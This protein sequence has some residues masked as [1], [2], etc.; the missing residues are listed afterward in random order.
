MIINSFRFLNGSAPE[1]P[2][3]GGA[4]AAD[5]LY[6]SLRNY[7]SWANAFIKIRRDSDN[8]EKW[9]FF[10][11][12]L[13]SLNS[14]VGDSRTTSS[15][16]TLSD[17]IGSANGYVSEWIGLNYTG[18]VDTSKIISNSTTTKQPK[19]INNGA[20]ITKNGLPAWDT[21]GSRFLEKRD[22]GI[23]ILNSNAEFTTISLSSQH[24]SAGTEFGYVIS[25]DVAQLTGFH[26]QNDNRATQKRNS[27]IRN[28][29]TT[30][31]FA[32]NLSQKNTTNQKLSSSVKTLTQLT[33]YYNNEQQV[34]VSWSGT[35]NNNGLIVG[36]DQQ[37]GGNMNGL[38]QEIRLLKGNKTSELQTIHADINSY[39]SIY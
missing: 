13:L 19:I 15:S 20:L 29:G 2:Q 10:N 30:F 17:W 31:Y 24:T 21:L 18:L 28:T 4:I 34:T 32:D 11:G 8:T 16:T 35:H 37:G 1:L 7:N 23:P 14:L 3:M 12:N 38:V 39:Y 27:F 33:S 6:F 36:A 9:V 26:N 22:A 25:T 5:D